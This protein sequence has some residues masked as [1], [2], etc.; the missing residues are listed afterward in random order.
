MKLEEF[1]NKIEDKEIEFAIDETK[2]GWMVDQGMLG[3][4]EYYALHFWSMIS[5]VLH[6]LAPISLFWLHWI[7]AIVIFILARMLWKAT[8]QSNKDFVLE[9]II[10]NEEFFNLC[11]KNEVL[12]VRD[13][14]T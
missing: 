11:I 1:I 7:W 9:K 6:L 14:V 10:R 8:K 3:K 2:A 4:S 13:K 12:I 5:F